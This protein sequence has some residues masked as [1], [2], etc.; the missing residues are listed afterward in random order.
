MRLLDVDGPLI[1]FLSSAFDFFVIFLLTVLF[2]I[3]VITA[4]AAMTAAQYVGMKIIRKEAPGVFKAYFHAFKVNFKQA[5]LL[6][7]VQLLLI[8][9][10]L[11][12]WY[13]VFSVGWNV[14]PLVYRVLLVLASF[15][16]LIFNLMLY[17]VISRFELKFKDAM[18]VSMVLSMANSPFLTI[19]V[20][21]IGLTAFLCIWFFNLLPAF[22][23]IGFTG[24]TALHALITN[25]ALEKMRKKM[26]E[27][28]NSEESA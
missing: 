17:A 24:T 11:F 6:W 21:C 22:F 12:D 1:S 23:V 13:V 20:A 18:K 7:L 26:E 19:V 5:T 9:F 4:G 28:S 27:T 16:V 8:L 10:L 2:S 14:V 15:V 3:P 25:R